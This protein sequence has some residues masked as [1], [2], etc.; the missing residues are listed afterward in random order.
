VKR[1]GIFVFLIALFATAGA[2]SS[3]MALHRLFKSNQKDSFQ[4]LMS[5]HLDSL[6]ADVESSWNETVT[7]LTDSGGADVKLES[8]S[9][10]I[11]ANGQDIP[12]AQ[13]PATR[14]LHFGSGGK[15]DGS[16]ID[17]D[18][19]SRLIP[20]LFASYVMDLPLEV[21]KEVKIDVKAG[22]NQTV[23]GSVTL[24]DVADGVAKVK[25]KLLF[26]TT[27][28]KAPMR[29]DAS[30]SFAVATS[31]LESIEGTIK[32][33]PARMTSR[34]NIQSADFKVKRLP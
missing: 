8:T 18:S 15:L 19:V 2:V 11:S 16:A 27:G 10:R 23:T 17:E 20:D 29:V 12:E 7:S 9:F 14:T 4:M 3:P 26:L 13:G 24:V 28:Q 22:P 1:L 33:L 25:M 31:R 34:Y 30:A 6:D 32:D 5:E 21:S